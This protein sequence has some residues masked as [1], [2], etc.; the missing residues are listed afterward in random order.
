[1][2][3]NKE[4]SKS[5]KCL[6][7]SDLIYT[8]T[9][10]FAE[11][12]LVAYF[13]K[14]TNENIIQ[15]SLYRIIVYALT[16]IGKVFMGNFIKNKPNIRTKILSLGIVIRA[17][18]ILFIVMLGDKLSTDFVIVAIFCGISETLYWSTHEL[19]YIDVTNNDNR[20]D[21]MSIK[22]ILSTIVKIVAPIILGSSIELYSFTK[23]AIYIFILSLI[24]IFIS[25]QINPNEY[26]IANNAE[27]YNI[28]KYIVKLK[29]NKFL[30]IRK[31]YKVSLVFGIIEDTMST[32]VTIIT[33]MTFK[34]SM[35]LG[36][37]T[38]IFSI[39]SMISLYLYKKIYNKSNSKIMLSVCSLLILIGVA[40][41]LFYIDRSTL[42]IYNFTYTI[43]ICILDAIYNTKKGDLVKECNI[44]KWNVEY[45]M[46]NGLLADISRI[47]GFTLM[48]IVGFINNIVMFKI[49]LFFV[50]LCV[51]LYSKLL[52]DL[53][54]EK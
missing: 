28:K 17:L 31:Y 23:I 39:C 4:L 1:M 3:Q 38:T 30:K 13:L 7:L 54:N 52:F 9:S 27:K 21:Y 40:G 49:L 48:L 46:V 14:I 11:T 41:L 37:L 5:A 53:E 6:I 42:I 24:Q 32:L 35:N 15:I 12:F 45:V 51:P 25:L 20:K 26:S 16:G 33:I 18:F 44:E 10:L 34:T 47:I 29:K 19:I 43:S 50:A 22:K 36:I 8:I 2:N